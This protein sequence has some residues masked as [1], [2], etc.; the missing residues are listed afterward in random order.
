MNKHI[1]RV[2]AKDLQEFPSKASF[3]DLYLAS[4]KINTPTTFAYRRNGK[5]VYVT[6]VEGDSECRALQE[7]IDNYWSR[8]EHLMRLVKKEVRRVIRRELKPAN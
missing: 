4:P 8:D 6:I 7:A 2:S 5:R 3:E 1:N